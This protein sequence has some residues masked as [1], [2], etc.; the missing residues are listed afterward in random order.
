MVDASTIQGDNVLF[1]DGTQTGVTVFGSTQ[2]GTEVA[3]TGTSNGGTTIRANG[4]QARLEG[5]LNTGTQNPNDTFTLDSLMFQLAGSHTFNNLEFNLFGGNAT[6]A[7]FTLVDNGGTSFQFAN[8]T[9]G[10]GENRFGFQGIDGQ[11]IRSISIAF[12]GGRRRR[13]AGPAR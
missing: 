2:S 12:T 11:T 10:N 1:N 6:A 8:N 13:A 7:T 5:T 3:F 9:L 4:G